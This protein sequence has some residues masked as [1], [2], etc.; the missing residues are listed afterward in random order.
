M[1]SSVDAQEMTAQ[2]YG[3]QNRGKRNVGRPATLQSIMAGHEL[4]SVLDPQQGHSASFDRASTAI[5]KSVA[6]PLNPV[7][8]PDAAILD[9]WSNA[10]EPL[11][12]HSI[13]LSNV[14]F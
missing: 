5:C 3:W 9:S 10:E 11:P 2:Q 7:S 1:L 12:H 8:Q 14:P 6:S 4:C 13:C